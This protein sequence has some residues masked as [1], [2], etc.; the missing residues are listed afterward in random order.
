MSRPERKTKEW[1]ALDVAHHLHPFTDPK[2]F[3]TKG[4]L[5]VTQAQGSHVWDSDGRKILDGM[6]GLWCVN[7]GYGRQEL[8]EASHRQMQELAYYNVFFQSATP[9]QIELSR[10]LAELTPGGLNHFFFTNSGSE[11][12]DT[13]IRM[14]RHYWEV[15]GKPSKQIFIGRTLG[16][17][18]S[19]LAATSLGGMSAMHAMGKSLLPGFDHIMHPHWYANGADLTPE[20]FGLRAA[21]ALEDKILALGADNVAAFVGEPVQ[22]AGGVIDPPATYWP[23]VQ[24]ICRKYDVL[25]VADEVI[26]GFGRLG[27]WFGSEAYGIEPD[28]MP[29][30]KGLSSGYLPIA[31]VAYGDRVQRAMQRGG[32]F[33]HGYTYSGHPVSCAVALANIQLIKDEGLIDRVHDDTAPY[34]RKRLYDAVADH[35]LVGEVRGAGLLAGIQLVQDKAT[36]ALFP[37]EDN[38]AMKCRD[39]CLDGGLIMRAVGQSMVASPPLII[40]HEEIDRMA[41]ILKESLDRTAAETG[42]A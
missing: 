10:V 5:V 13:I 27:H 35:P 7:V 22:G 41:A 11:A 37:A 26:C 14:V 38:V 6:A 18:G 40:S 3:D 39:H 24:R 9:P 23:E 36:R 4:P 19:T 15:E 42:A 8:I 28:L 12:N 25:L 2:Y 33:S 30:A 34:F 17:H 32:V 20:E 1:Q 21:R 29:M 16:Y 31:A